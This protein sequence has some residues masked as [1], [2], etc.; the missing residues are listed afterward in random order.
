MQSPQ[1]TLNILYEK[2]ETGNRLK[3]IVNSGA[4]EIIPLKIVVTI[5]SSHAPG[6]VYTGFRASA[7]FFKGNDRIDNIASIVKDERFWSLIEYYQKEIIALSSKKK[8]I[9]TDNKDAQEPESTIRQSANFATKFFR[10]INLIRRFKLFGKFN[11]DLLLAFQSFCQGLNVYTLCTSSKDTEIIIACTTIGISADMTTHINSNLFYDKLAIRLA[12]L[13]LGNVIL[14][15]QLISKQI[16]DLTSRI[17][18]VTSYTRRR[19]LPY[20]LVIAAIHFF[21]A[22]YIYYMTPGSAPFVNPGNLFGILV[23]PLMWPTTAFF[24]RMYTPRIISHIVRY[25]I[26]R[27]LRS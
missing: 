3:V 10:S 1:Y 23:A 7:E 21:S 15:T 25:A 17:E 6:G 16:R 26:N 19:A 13:H 20:S 4:E 8:L 9:L 5:P 24:V 22:Y 2:P 18:N 12:Y 14:A 11:S 27:I